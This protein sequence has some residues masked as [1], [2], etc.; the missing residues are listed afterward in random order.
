MM[1]SY[2]ALLESI[3]EH[4]EEQ[5][6]YLRIWSEGEQRQLFAQSHSVQIERTA[7]VCMHQLFETQAEITPGA[8]A[9]VFDDRSL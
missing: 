1:S 8:T 4:P 9:V 5:I 2:G 7:A 6:G 3:L